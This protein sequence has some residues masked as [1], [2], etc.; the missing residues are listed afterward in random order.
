MFI[1]TNLCHQPSCDDGFGKPGLAPHEGGATG[2][3]ERQR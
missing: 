3:V 1:S 2:R